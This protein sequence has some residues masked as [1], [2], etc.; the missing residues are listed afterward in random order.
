MPRKAFMALLPGA[1]LVVAALLWPSPAMAQGQRGLVI[2]VGGFIYSPFHYDPFWGPYPYLG[3]GAYPIGART[4]GDVRAPATPKQADVYVDGF[5]PGLVDDFDCV[6]QH[7]RSCVTLADTF[8]LQFAMDR[9]PVDETITPPPIP[10][11][12]LGR[13]QAQLPASPFL[14]G[15]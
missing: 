13:G 11:R 2:A 6:F 1:L 7:L 8:K 9:L 5:Y 12:S 14:P 15:T 10:A 4:S 3:Y